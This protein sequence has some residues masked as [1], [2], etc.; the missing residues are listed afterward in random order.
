MTVEGAATGRMLILACSQRKL[1]DEGL[2]PAV[3]RY[4]D[5]AFRVLRRF[6]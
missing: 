4:D 1:L 5:P 3:E 6:L 2:L